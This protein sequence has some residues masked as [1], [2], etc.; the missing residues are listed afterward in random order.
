MSCDQWQA[1]LVPIST[2]N[3][4]DQMRSLDTHCVLVPP[5]AR[6]HSP[7]PVQTRR[8]RPP[9]ALRAQPKFR[10]Q[11]H[12]QIADKPPR[13]WRFRWVLPR[14]RSE[15]CSSPVWLLLTCKG[16]SGAATPLQ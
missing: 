3:P 11:V 6:M 2:V 14:L 13:G 10:S 4:G 16:K 15:F 1:Q 12:K 9:A 5:A 7:S 8:Q